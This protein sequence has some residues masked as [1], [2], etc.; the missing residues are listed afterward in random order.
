MQ[1]PRAIVVAATGLSLL[2]VA[3]CGGSPQPVRPRAASASPAKAAVNLPTKDQLATDYTA[4]ST[5]KNDVWRSSKAQIEAGTTLT[6]GKGLGSDMATA[7]WTFIEKLR[8]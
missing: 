7:N 2:S 1:F 3:A 4:A 6:K 8:A 5:A